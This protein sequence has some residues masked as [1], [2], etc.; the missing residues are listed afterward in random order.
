MVVCGA[1]YEGQ[2]PAHV[3]VYWYKGEPSPQNALTNLMES[4]SPRGGRLYL[5]GGHSNHYRILVISN[6]TLADAGV[7]TCEVSVPLPPPLVSQHGNGTRLH[8]EEATSCVALKTPTVMK[9]A[10]IIPALS[11]YSMVLTIAVMVL[12]VLLRFHMKSKSTLIT[13]EISRG[14]EDPQP[15][16][17][18]GHTRS[19]AGDRSRETH[20]QEYEDMTVFRTMNQR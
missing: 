9:Q 1:H 6:L 4:G 19:L 11:I 16:T 15:N 20:P 14:P 3:D 12:A 8:V 13:K 18:R 10:I 17:C 2:V 5:H 7:Y